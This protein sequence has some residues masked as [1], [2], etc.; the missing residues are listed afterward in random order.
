MRMTSVKPASRRPSS[1]MAERTGLSST[2]TIL[3]VRSMPVPEPATGRPAGLGARWFIFGP[4]T[5][6]DFWP[7]PL[8]S[9]WARPA[10]HFGTPSGH[11][12][13]GRSR[14]IMINPAHFHDN[15]G[16]GPAAGPAKEP[17]GRTPM[18]SQPSVAP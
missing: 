7:D 11:S 14:I 1:R 12:D 13:P 8:P 10:M 3:T 6:E 2:I 4:H 17:L 18:S 9:E 5:Q 16:S 15:A